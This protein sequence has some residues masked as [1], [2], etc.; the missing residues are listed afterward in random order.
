MLRRA[1]GLGLLGLGACLLGAA[2]AVRLFLVPGLVKLPLDQKAAPVAQGTNISFFDIGEQEQLEGLEATVQQRVQGDPTADGASG[3]VAVWNFGS[4]MTA[5]DGTVLNA[6]TYRVCLDRHTA[7]AVT[8]CPST[9]V[10]ND[11]G[12]TITGLTLTFPFGTEQ[13]DYDV[14]NATTGRAF[15]AEFQGVEELEGVEVYK[16]VQTVP[17]T[18]ISETQVPAAMAGE[19]GDGT[20]DAEIVYSNVRT[21]WVEPASG[22]IV[23]AEEHPDTVL[24]GPDGSTG[25]TILAGDFSASAKTLADGVERANDTRSKITLVQTVLPLVLA[26]LGVL[27][28]IA[29]GLLLA[30]AARTEGDDEELSIIDEGRVPQHL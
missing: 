23:T 19:S 14:F 2:L 1:I 25:V 9:H 18:V 4:V 10:D 28:L 11:R 24:R 8:D 22:V 16:F 26:G 3:D 7:E 5:T 20:V 17:E 12:A 15:T 29:A 27:L 21:M 6:S 13:R 30:R